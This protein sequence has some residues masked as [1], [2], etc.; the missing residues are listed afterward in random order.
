MNKRRRDKALFHNWATWTLFTILCSAAWA[1][2]PT[3][4][5][6]NKQYS[7]AVE[8]YTQQA[9][10]LAATEFE[11]FLNDF[12]NDKRRPMAI[13][14]WGE[15]HWVE[16]KYTKAL[17]IFK[18]FLNDFPT[19]ERHD[20][21]LF[22]TANC[23]IELKDYA[24]AVK[25]LEQFVNVSNKEKWLSY[26]YYWLAECNYKQSRLDQAVNW[27]EKVVDKFPE[28]AYTTHALYN[29]ASV[30][31]QQGKQA[32]AVDPLKK[33][34]KDFP[35][36]ELVPNA[37][38]LL[39][40]CYLDL[41]RL[42]E[43]TASYITVIE[44]HPSSDVFVDS[45][46]GFGRVKF[47][48]K[49][50]EGALKEFR[51]VTKAEMGTPNASTASVMMGDCA[52]ILGRYEEAARHYLNG[53]I[54]ASTNLAD[55]A[56]FWAGTARLNLKEHAVASRLFLR[57]LDEHP[58]S[59]NTLLAQLKLGACYFELEQYNNAI[60]AYQM[61][62]ARV[63]ESSNA[64]VVEALHGSARCYEKI[65]KLNELL[66]TYG[67]LAELHPNHKSTSQVALLVGKLLSDNHQP[68]KAEPVYRNILQ[69]PDFSEDHP[70]A[71]MGLAEV[72]VSRKRYDRAE[73]ILREL[74]ER[75]SVTSDA[76]P[77]LLNT[78]VAA[79]NDGKFRS[80]VSIYQILL[81][82]LP[83]NEL[84]PNALFGQ[85][86]A[87]Y[88]Q[89]DYHNSVTVY[90]LLVHKHQDHPLSTQANFWLGSALLK[91]TEASRLE[92][93]QTVTAL[94][95]ALSS[96]RTFIAQ[97]GETEKA[98]NLPEAH[99]D[100]GRCLHELKRFDDAVKAFEMLKDQYP[101]SPQAKDA[102]YQIGWAYKSNNHSQK[103]L[104]V[105]KRFVATQP[106]SKNAP[107]G[108]LLIGEFQYQKE[109]FEEAITNYRK[110]IE[111]A[112][113]REPQGQILYRLGWALKA[114]KQFD[115]ASNAFEQVM[116]TQ[117]RPTLKADA[118]FR[119]GSIAFERKKFA[120]AAGHFRS[121]LKEFADTDEVP[122]AT[123]SLGECL[124][125]MGQFLDAEKTLRQL[126]NVKPAKALAAKTRV[127]LGF[128]LQNQ[129][130]MD[131]ALAEYQAALAVPL[132]AKGETAAQARYRIGECML[133]KKQYDEALSE[134]INVLAH[135]RPHIFWAAAAQYKIGECWERQKDIKKARGAYQ[136]VVTDFPESEHAKQAKKRLEPLDG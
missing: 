55:H 68:D 29:S 131:A 122:E 132:S 61:L 97:I 105:F 111:L 120:L 100:L 92:T 24:N 86:A 7:R 117:A 11:K 78:A 21:A 112:T 49:N 129:K 23:Y 76:A 99:F 39:G 9:Y 52:Y 91:I 54:D 102:L 25:P 82:R 37:H 113:D 1:Q 62:L 33:L 134:F 19:H 130:K 125:S 32:K 114:T 16:K 28:S 58:D 44:K 133:Q 3:S 51:R 60:A 30:Y 35:K 109:Q 118:R 95:E 64:K 66:V 70:Y 42:P 50:W 8:L 17:G 59:A 26:A 20:R 10:R 115:E 31:R 12:P 106:D 71:F 46:M 14:Y 116:A 80:A 73:G 123:H 38:W 57:I 136:K 43:A 83:E 63:P 65:N 121:V 119:M 72:E 110:G 89:K 85:G 69:N 96:F 88:T 45:L 34:V 48:E 13:I 53:A 6:A 4:D 5:G 104:E 127:S 90:R 84:V 77:T 87:Y 56:L 75:T 15:S 98:T 67:K 108:C 2:G 22:R 135:Y 124:N 94:E 40:E 47:A 107:R 81:D 103:A 93:E 128:A 79:Y 41:K 18:S 36:S 74:M 126:L 27:Y 101:G